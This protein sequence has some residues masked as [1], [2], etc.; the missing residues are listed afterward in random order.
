MVTESTL[1][2]LLAA[3]EQGSAEAQQALF[4][5]L[6]AELKAMA[7]WE[8]ARHGGVALG[9]GTL[10]HETYLKLS[11]RKGLNFPDRARFLAYAARAMRGLVIDHARRR[12]AHK[13]HGDFLLTGLP[14]DVPDPVDAE[15]LTR[16]GDAVDALAVQAPA[17]A[18]LVDLKYFCGYS[19]VEVAA[20]RGV[21]E[22]TVQRDWEKARI[23]LHR[24]LRE[25]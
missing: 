11:R 4:A 14:T 2:P 9:A 25:S 23:V 5:E 15:E 6:Y 20:L 21:S 16:L 10:L 18:E 7:Q 8:L 3:A 17:L 1:E 13:R 22:R 19:F 12:Q 24:M